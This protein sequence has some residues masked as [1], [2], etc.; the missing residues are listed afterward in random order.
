MSEKTGGSM[1]Y[2][3][4]VTVDTEAEASRLATLLADNVDQPIDVDFVTEEECTPPKS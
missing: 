2:E 4:R 1:R 3:V